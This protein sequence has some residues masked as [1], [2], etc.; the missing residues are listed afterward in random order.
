MSG[1]EMNVVSERNETKPARQTEKKKRGR[2]GG[3]E[4]VKDRLG[5]V[6]YAE[7]KTSHRGFCSK[8]IQLV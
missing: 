2:H 8:R 4:P 3:S 5:S 7:V 6:P 1:D